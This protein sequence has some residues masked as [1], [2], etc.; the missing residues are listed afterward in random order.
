M[1][2]SLK[3]RRYIQS[4]RAIAQRI[5]KKNEEILEFMQWVYFLALQQRPTLI[6]FAARQTCCSIYPLTDC[7]PG[8][9]Y[10]YLVVRRPSIRCKA[11]TP[12]S[13]TDATQQVCTTAA[14]K[15]QR[16]CTVAFRFTRGDGTQA[17]YSS[18]V[19]LTAD[20]L[21]MHQTGYT[22]HVP[23]MSSTYNTSV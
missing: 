14:Q 6:L 1:A 11:S 19:K 2:T 4:Y 18:S 23:A 17:S 8:H 7:G 15:L 20:L 5:S 16:S 10:I 3:N 9:H 21:A 12:C 22:T 13:K